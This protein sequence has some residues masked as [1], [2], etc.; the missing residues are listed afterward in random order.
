[1]IHVKKFNVVV[2]AKT[3]KIIEVSTKKWDIDIKK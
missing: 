2:S 1:M 3:R